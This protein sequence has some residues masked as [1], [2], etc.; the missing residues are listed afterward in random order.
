MIKLLH[1]HFDGVLGF[2]W[3]FDKERVGR[4]REK[5]NN[6]KEEDRFQ[7]EIALYENR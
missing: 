4:R 5:K 3:V 6:K 2:V 1:G 7:G